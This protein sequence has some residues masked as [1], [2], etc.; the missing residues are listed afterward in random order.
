VVKQ[1]LAA[2]PNLTPNDVRSTSSGATGRDILLSEAALDV[3]RYSCECKSRK[4]Y[5][6]YRD[7]EQAESNTAAG[8]VP[9]LIVKE[10]N[11]RPLAVVDFEHF[12]SLVKGNKNKN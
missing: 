3:F 9:L 5:A 6:V 10:N 2:F 12:L 1:I 11:K 4:S 8:E 7:L